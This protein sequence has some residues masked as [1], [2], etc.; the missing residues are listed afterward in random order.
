MKVSPT[1]RMELHDQ[2]SQHLAQ[3]SCPSHLV[4]EQE[5]QRSRA[6]RRTNAAEDWNLYWMSILY[7][8]H[9]VQAVEKALQWSVEDM[10]N[11]SSRQA[12][13]A[14]VYTPPQL[15]HIKSPATSQPRCC[16]YEVNMW[17]S[18]AY[19]VLDM[20]ETPISCRN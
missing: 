14:Q 17:Q 10:A 5:T 16:S 4:E 18:L 9:T 11:N 3:V 19:G 15:V 8:K 1:I 13:A 20:V 6:L 7:Q 12:S 2:Q